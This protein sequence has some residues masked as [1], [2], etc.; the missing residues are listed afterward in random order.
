MQE[1]TLGGTSLFSWMFCV[2]WVLG[3]LA[4][5]AAGTSVAWLL[6]SQTGKSTREVVRH[7]LSD[8]AGFAR[9]LQDRLMR[10]DQKTRRQ[11]RHRVGNGSAALAEVVGGGAD[12]VRETQL[13]R[14]STSKLRP[15]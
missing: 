11:P 3:F 7:W 13:V 10:R 4:G 9:D 14:P 15:A 1:R 8:A 2:L 6:A 12:W 5:G